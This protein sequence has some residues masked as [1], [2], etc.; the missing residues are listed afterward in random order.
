MKT[1][2]RV[3]RP[4]KLPPEFRRDAVEIVLD[5]SRPYAASGPFT[6]TAEGLPPILVSSPHRIALGEKGWTDTPDYADFNSTKFATHKS[7]RGRPGMAGC[8]A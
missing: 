6:R 2:S 8:S 4:S 5:E 7:Q 1:R 3:G